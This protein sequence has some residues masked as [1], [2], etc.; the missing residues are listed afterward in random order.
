MTKA[1]RIFVLTMVL[2]AALLTSL[3][4]LSEFNQGASPTGDITIQAMGT[5]C[6]PDQIWHACFPALTIF[7]TF[8]TAGIMTLILTGLLITRTVR[9]FRSHWQGLSLLLLGV[10]LLLSGGGFIAF[11]ILLVAS[12]A[13]FFMPNGKSETKPIHRKMAKGWP[14]LLFFYFLIVGLQVLLGANSNEFAMQ[15]VTLLLFFQTLALVLAAFAAHA[16]DIV[17]DKENL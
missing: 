9:P 6:M 15:I 12:T 2:Y 8:D 1:T 4:G 11:F 10:L 14:C 3:H 16:W 13:A 5:P 17:K 7:H